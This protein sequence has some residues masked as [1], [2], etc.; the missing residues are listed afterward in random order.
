MSRPL[1]T[2]NHP[3]HHQSGAGIE[4]IEVIEAF[5]L[6]FCLGNTVKYILRAGKKG[7]RVEDLKKARWYLDRE[8]AAAEK[9]GG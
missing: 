8:I 2:V 1:E 9:S 6:G 4:A 5:G 3:A 7:G